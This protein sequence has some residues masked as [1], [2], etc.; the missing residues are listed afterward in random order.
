MSKIDDILKEKQTAEP[1]EP[2]SKFYSTVSADG[3]DENF[4]ELRFSNGLQTGFSYSDLIWYS[5]DPEQGTID[6][7][8]GGFLVTITGRGLGNH[9]LHSI[10]TRTLA[11][12]KEADSDFED[13]EKTETYI[14]E[15]SITPPEGFGEESEEGE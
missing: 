6:M 14:S 1:L 15:I 8:F 13:N 12:L 3:H 9:L 5:H 2:D 10:K 7:E 4:L 11:W